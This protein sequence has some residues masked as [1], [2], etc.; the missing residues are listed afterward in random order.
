[1]GRN[2]P[3]PTQTEYTERD[4]EPVAEM[5]VAEVGRLR[6]QRPGWSEIAGIY[7]QV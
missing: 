6:A 4:Q 7:F 5:V 1:M 3:F 2:G